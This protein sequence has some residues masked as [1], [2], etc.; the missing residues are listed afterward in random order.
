[1]LNIRTLIIIFFS[2]IGFGQNDEYPREHISNYDLVGKVKYATVTTINKKGSYG[3]PNKT[4]AFTNEY[5][6]NNDG[7]LLQDYLTNNDGF[8]YLNE[9]NV[10]D[11][12][13]KIL[14]KIERARKSKKIGKKRG[15][16]DQL[17][18]Y[19]EKYNYDSHGNLLTKYQKSDIEDEFYLA[20]K[21]IYDYGFLVE[22]ISLNNHLPQ[23]AIGYSSDFRESYKIINE[24]NEE[25]NYINSKTY[26]YETTEFVRNDDGSFKEY[27]IYDLDKLKNT[28]LILESERIKKYNDLGQLVS[29]NIKFHSGNYLYENMN[30]S[31]EYF[32]SKESKR[33]F[34]DDG[35]INGY[36]LD[37]VVI[38]NDTL[39]SKRLNFG[40][41]NKDEKVI[42]RLEFEIIY[43][44]DRSYKKLIYDTDGNLEET[45]F[46]DKYGNFQSRIPEQKSDLKSEK[47]YDDK[48]NLVS[49]KLFSISKNKLLKSVEKKIEYYD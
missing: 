4:I 8:R 22:E 27:V 33:T 7:F 25:E 37:Y 38:K 14:L 32:G 9:E 23:S 2:F 11:E 24:R 21:N 35:M 45:L 47:I 49:F 30:I 3:Y 5:M 18:T 13:N 42:E 26:K 6:F 1:M 44:Q 41:Y 39:I 31:Y 16:S 20:Q 36:T 40:N 12:D 17:L 29:E 15:F 46:Y 19:Q 10:Y 28:K 43:N 34:D 48:G